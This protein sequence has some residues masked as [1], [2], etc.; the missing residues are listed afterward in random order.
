MHIQELMNLG[1]CSSS[2]SIKCVLTRNHRK[3]LGQLS[4]AALHRYIHLHRP[5]SKAF[6]AGLNVS[7]Y[8][9]AST[10][11]SL[12]DLAVQQQPS[13][14]SSLGSYA[15]PMP[16]GI[17][18]MS[19]PTMQYG[20][21]P[22]FSIVNQGKGK[23]READFEAAFAQVAASLGPIEAQ[24][25]RVEEVDDS[26]ADIEDTLKNVSLKSEE[27][28]Y[29]TD[30]KMYDILISLININFWIQDMGS[31]TELRYDYTNRRYSKMGSTVF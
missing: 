20:S 28:E 31:T 3:P 27:A 24:T 1:L 5:Y 17:Y 19:P 18:S 6:Q 9:C 21:N 14:M 4:L 7:T 12:H 30:Y 29:G 25:S 10:H 15:S 2:S 23:G 26:I 22:N 8:I 13:Y 11:L 16:I